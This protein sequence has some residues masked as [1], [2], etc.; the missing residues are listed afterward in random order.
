MSTKADLDAVNEMIASLNQALAIASPERR[1]FLQAR[2]KRWEGKRDAIEQ[3]LSD[4]W[5]VSNNLD[6]V[7]PDGTRHFG[8]E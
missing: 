8:G 2:I 4:Q 1:A 7:F 5:A 6:V 3:S